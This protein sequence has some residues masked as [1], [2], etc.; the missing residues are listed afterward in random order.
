M[1]VSLWR[2][3]Y[4]PMVLSLALR[5]LKVNKFRTILSMIGIVIGVFAICSMGM[6]SSGFVEEINSSLLDSSA[7][8]EIS[9]IEERVS[10]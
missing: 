6:V 10:R 7:T 9:S 2:K 5:N 4:S 3:I 8:L 1:S